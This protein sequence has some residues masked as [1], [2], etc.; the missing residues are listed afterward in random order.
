M[1]AVFFLLNFQFLVRNLL[2]EW[3]NSYIQF[4]LTLKTKNL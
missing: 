4:I 3:T 2:T 1:V